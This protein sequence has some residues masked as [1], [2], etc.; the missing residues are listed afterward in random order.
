MKH[1]KHYQQGGV[2]KDRS[3]AQSQEEQMRAQAEASRGL[4]EK[5]EPMPLRKRT[6]SR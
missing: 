5:T 1:G 3:I 6:K 4:V 2:P